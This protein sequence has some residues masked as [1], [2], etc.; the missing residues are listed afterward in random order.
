MPARSRRIDV[1]FAVVKRRGLYLICQRKAGTH[2][3]GCWEFPGGKRE[4]GESWLACLRREIR[5]ELGVGVVRVKPW[6]MLLHRYPGKH[7]RFKVFRCG[8]RGTPKAL[9]I[10]QLRWVLAEQ[11]SRFKFPP[12]DAR[13]IRRLACPSKPAML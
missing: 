10:K 6:T 11:L 1:A 12:A 7:I 5:E 4:P 9:Q 3:A 13:L 2:L 8:L